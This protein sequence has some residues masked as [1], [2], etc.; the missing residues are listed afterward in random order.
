MAVNLSCA[1]NMLSHICLIN[2]IDLIFEF[3]GES[4]NEYR[5]VGRRKLESLVLLWQN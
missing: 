1:H 4:S 5:K 3:V 2:F